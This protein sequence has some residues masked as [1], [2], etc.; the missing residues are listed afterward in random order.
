[1][2]TAH[3]AR[4]RVEA[5]K[6][7]IA[8]RR[9]VDARKILV[10]LTTELSM[11]PAAE[12]FLYLDGIRDRFDGAGGTATSEAREFEMP[13]VIT[14]I[15]E[16]ANSSGVTLYPIDSTGKGGGF[17]DRDAAVVSRITSGDA[18]QQTPLMPSLRPIAAMTGGVAFT[19][20]DNWKLAFDTVFNDL[21]NYYSLGYRLPADRHDR[22][23]K[24][25]VR[26][27]N[28]RYTVRSRQTVIEKSVTS[29]MRDAVAANLFRPAAVNDLA[30]R[31]VAGTAA[32]NEGASILIPLTVTIPMDKL[33]LIPDGADLTGRFAVYAAF[34]RDDGALSKI[35]QTP[36]QVRFPAQSLK[37]RKELTVKVDL[38]VDPR[39][40]LLSVG[41][42][43]EAART[44]G[45]ASV[46]LQ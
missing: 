14:E 13:A 25:E 22:L 23:K 32:P 18:I 38:T 27:K 35:V 26:L 12:P 3:D 6:S 45:F 20:T 5:M 39:T 17:Q 37:Q 9:G 16:V 41:V 29:E 4:A 10:L 36:G 28:K 34:L 46:K 40:S 2:R 21:E 43:D 30:I 44:T 31:A 42:M 33:T 8:W 1:M 19:G 15:S 7:V 11:N 24:V